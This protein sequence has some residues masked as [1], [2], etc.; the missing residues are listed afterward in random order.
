MPKLPFVP[1]QVMEVLP[2]NI[3]SAEGEISVHI[4]INTNGTVNEYKIIRN[5]TTHP[6]CLNAVVKALNK[7]RWEAVSYNGGKI[8]Y[9]VEKNY[10]FGR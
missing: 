9:W 8:E 5:T 1:R 7:S 3:E 4:R 2:K 10:I 6:E